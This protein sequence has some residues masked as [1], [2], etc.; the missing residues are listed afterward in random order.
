MKRVTS[1]GPQD[2]FRNMQIFFLDSQIQDGY[3]LILYGW[4]LFRSVFGGMAM[5]TPNEVRW[6]RTYTLS[7]F[8][9]VLFIST[10]SQPHQDE[11]PKV[12][13]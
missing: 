8:A 13:I 12:E 10:A 3:S 4:P 7:L 11:N 9:I 6:H 2:F 5:F 1:F